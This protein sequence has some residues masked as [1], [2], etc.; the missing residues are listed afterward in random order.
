M[1]GARERTNAF[2]EYVRSTELV[3]TLVSPRIAQVATDEI[4]DS[5]R[6]AE[7]Y[8]EPMRRQAETQ[9]DKETIDSLDSIG[10]SLTVVKQTYM[11]LCNCCLDDDIEKEPATKCCQTIEQALSK[12]IAEHEELMKR[13][14]EKQPAE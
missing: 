7:K 12:A 10:R 3:P 1:R 14:G 9:K 11:R 8:L 5:I 2:R 13:L 6:K 4:G